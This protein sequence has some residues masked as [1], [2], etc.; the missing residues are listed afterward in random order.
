MPGTQDVTM[1]VDPIEQARTWRRRLHE[2]PGL[3]FDVGEAE[4]FVATIATGLG[5][6]VERGIGEHGVVAT[7]RRGTSRRAI[8]LR[9]DMDGLAIDEE[10]GAEYASRNAGVMHACGH[11]GHMAMLLGAAAALAE[12]SDFDGTVHLFF[13][14]AEEPGLGALAMI[15]DGVF[16]RFP[17]DAIYGLHNLPGIPAGE[18]HTRSGPIMA[19]E[20]NF[21]IRVT[22]RGGHASM[23]HLV[24]D[25]LLVGAEIVSALQTIVARSAD[26]S[27]GVVVSCTEFTTDGARNAIPGA[28]VIRG[29]ART[30]TEEDSLLVE[31]RMRALCSGIAA[32][33]GASCEVG[34]TRE[35]RPTVN[36]PRCTEAVVAAAT[37]SVGAERVNGDGARLMASED[38]G[39]FARVVP[40]CF[41]F[42]GTGTEAGAGGTP[43]HSR[44]YDFNDEVLGAGI[45]FYVNLVTSEL[46]IEE[47]A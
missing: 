28:A 29:D 40:G 3:A 19:A 33:H 10:T 8:A 22:G 14:P 7:L 43:L 17:V 23:P 30:F 25:P 12:R 21:E 27:H 44:D 16:E 2:R 39:E 6:E 37:A 47:A 36:D 41:A 46:A 34:Y 18:L 24:I 38:F 4:E 1:T 9:S 42:L 26:P 35:F 11:D 5:W 20:D 13:Q 15:A 32:A 45:D 31:R